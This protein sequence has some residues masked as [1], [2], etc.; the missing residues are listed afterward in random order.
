V[1]VEKT[2]EVSEKKTTRKRAIRKTSSASSKKAVDA[3]DSE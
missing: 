3:N 1:K 2:V